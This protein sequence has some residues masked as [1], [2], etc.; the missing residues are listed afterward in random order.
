[1]PV[2]NAFGV[3]MAIEKLKRHKT[4]DI[5]Q[6]PTEI[7]RTAQKLGRVRVVPRVCGFYYDICLTTEEKA[8]KTLSHGSHT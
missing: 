2:P 8:R 4:Q 1:V 6:I 3:Q 7:H 5:D